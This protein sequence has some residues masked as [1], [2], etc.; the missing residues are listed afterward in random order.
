MK[1]IKSALNGFALIFEFQNFINIDPA[2]I[3]RFYHKENNLQ[4]VYQGH[5]VAGNLEGFGRIMDNLGNMQ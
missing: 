2:S 5:F 4:A 3:R 1:K